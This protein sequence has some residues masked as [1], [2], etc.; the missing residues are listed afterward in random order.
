MLKACIEF[1][2]Q[3]HYSLLV[4]TETFEVERLSHHQLRL[5]PP[6]L[7][8]LA[9]L[10]AETTLFSPRCS[11]RVKGTGGRVEWAVGTV[12]R[13]ADGNGPPW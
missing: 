11:V 13:S 6:R 10:R 3:I 12:D 2:V 9:Q 4:E 7:I 8:S 1:T 5:S